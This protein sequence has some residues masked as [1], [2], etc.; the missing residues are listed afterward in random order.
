V[1]SIGAVRIRA[2]VRAPHRGTPSRS[3]AWAARPDRTSMGGGP[4]YA[5]RPG[6]HARLGVWVEGGRGLRRD[7]GLC[8]DAGVL[9]EGKEG[10]TRGAQLRP[11]DTGA[12]TVDLV[13]REAARLRRRAGASR[14]LADLCLRDQTRRSIGGEYLHHPRRSRSEQTVWAPC[15]ARAA[16]TCERESQTLFRSR[17]ARENDDESGGIPAREPY[18]AGRRAAHET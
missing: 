3:L 2:D 15:L 10:C 4:V 17:S 9:R 13:S 11:R 7:V 5:R 14:T 6:A 1:S 8:E 16:T 12:C 18:R